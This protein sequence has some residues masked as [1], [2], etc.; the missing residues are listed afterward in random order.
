MKKQV[1]NII[2]GDIKYSKLPT[3]YYKHCARRKLKISSS[4]LKYI[5]NQGIFENISIQTKLLFL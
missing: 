2:N 5:G 1:T 3:C 4:V